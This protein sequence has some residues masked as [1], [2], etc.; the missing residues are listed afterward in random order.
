MNNLFKVPC[1]LSL[2]IVASCTNDIATNTV[3]LQQKT[4]I[5]GGTRAQEGDLVSMSTAWLM[6]TSGGNSSECAGILVS[7]NLIITAGHCVT[8]PAEY[9]KNPWVFNVILDPN[10]SGNAPLA[11]RSVGEGAIGHENFKIEGPFDVRRYDIGVIKLK[12]N[13][14]SSL[15]PVPL[16]VSR[17]NIKP[18]TGIVVAGYGYTDDR[19]VTDGRQL[20]VVDSQVQAFFDGEFDADQS[21]GKGA[22][23]GDSGGPAYVKTKQGLALLGVVSG[24]SMRVEQNWQSTCKVILTYTEISAY[25]D[26]ILESAKKL[27]AIPPQFIEMD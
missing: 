1:L 16:I 12:E 8:F 15:K 10:I 4:A 27:N 14:S 18:G 26:F 11:H 20:R 22:C 24:P 25:K 21:N 17:K 19:D 3:D 7:P 2:L 9:S 6:A 13:V 23:Q 5:I